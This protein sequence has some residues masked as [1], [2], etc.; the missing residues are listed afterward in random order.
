MWLSDG[1]DDAFVR[2]K[3]ERD[4]ECKPLIGH[5]LDASHFN[6]YYLLVKN[7]TLS[8]DDKLYEQSRLI[9]GR[10]KTTV[11]ALVREYL[12]GLS[13]AEPRREK[14]RRELLAMIGSFGG[15]VGR[16]PSREERNGRR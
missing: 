12:R 13:N 7:I 10:R 14:A 8:I 15:K 5:K 9:A 16:M 4:E 3:P 6:R 2:L 1:T 11:N